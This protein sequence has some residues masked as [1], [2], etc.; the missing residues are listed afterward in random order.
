MSEYNAFIVGAIVV[1]VSAILSVGGLLIVRK[2]V[3]TEKLEQFNNVG[4]NMFQVVGTLYAVLIGL[5]V[6]DALQTVNDLRVTID[7]E[8]SAVANIYTLAGGLPSAANLKIKKT[9]TNY[10]DLVIDEEWEAMSHRSYSR[11]AVISVHS[12][13]KTLIECEPEKS[14]QQDIRTMALDEMRDLSD[15]RRKRLLSSIHGVSPILWAALILG[16]ALTIMFTYFFG[17]SSLPGQIM[18]TVIVSTCLS[19]NIYLV[20]LFGYPFSGIFRLPP[21]GFMANRAIIKVFK[22]GI[23]SVPENFDL[24]KIKD[25]RGNIQDSLEAIDK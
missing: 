24:Q 1:L 6:V 18:M 22:K 7:H 21:E 3:S 9:I 8:A 14:T 12:L 25:K 16:G 15:C 5:V 2:K 4:G 11:G 17:M 20:F 19:L 10:V 23:E 13:W